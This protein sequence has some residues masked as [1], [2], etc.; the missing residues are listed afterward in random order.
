MQ[1][2]EGAVA[3]QYRY[4]FLHNVLADVPGARPHH[5]GIHRS[6]SGCGTLISARVTDLILLRRAVSAE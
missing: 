6:I 1:T 3:K 5:L 4:T 2:Q